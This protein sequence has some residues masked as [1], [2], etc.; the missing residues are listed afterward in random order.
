[1]DP[2]G[3]EDKTR[4]VLIGATGSVVVYCGSALFTYFCK[5]SD[6]RC[7]LTRRALMRPEVRRCAAAA[8]GA[9]PRLRPI[10]E[11]YAMVMFEAQKSRRASHRTTQGE[12]ASLASIMGIKFQEVLQRLRANMSYAE[13]RAAFAEWR[14]AYVTLH[15]A[16]PFTAN[17]ALL[18]SVDYFIM[19]YEQNTVRHLREYGHAANYVAATGFTT[20]LN[21]LI[22]SGGMVPSHTLS[23]VTRFN[24]MVQSRLQRRHTRQLGN[25]ERQTERVRSIAYISSSS[26]S[27]D[28]DHTPPRRIRRRVASPGDVTDTFSPDLST[29]E[30][31]ERDGSDSIWITD[32][33]TARGSR[34]DQ[35]H[36]M[37]HGAIQSA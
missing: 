12:L 19:D 16:D 26:E 32:T 34:A 2:V 17:S 24:S 36:P 35:T 6:Y 25:F 37:R 21:Y 15:E 11:D 10:L 23:R 5:T 4:F 14:A 33:V 28:E 3:K 9:D 8:A 27:E 22:E 30:Y 29:H 1:M 18:S 7:P 13:R 20:T 31:I